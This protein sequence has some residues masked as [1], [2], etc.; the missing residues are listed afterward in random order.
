MDKA[1]SLA[2]ARLGIGAAAYAAPEL[3][4]KAMMLDHTH[5]ETPIFV[6][7]FGVRDFALGAATL[8]AK[9]QHKRAWLA[10]GMLVDA[11]D[12][13]V[14]LLALR[15]GAVKPAVGMALTGAGASAALVALVAIAQQKK[16]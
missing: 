15:S 16:G 9:P 1:T 10:L 14:G 4:L 5:L 13:G 7:L 12:A 6:R 2:L 3:S 11:G 8:V